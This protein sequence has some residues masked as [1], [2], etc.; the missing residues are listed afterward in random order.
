MKKWNELPSEMQVAEVKEYYDILEKR[1]AS[2]VLKR[3]FD[4]IASGIMIVILTPVMLILALFIKLD[5]KGPVMFRQR[6]VTTYNRVFRIYKFR[7]MVQNAESRGTQVTTNNDPRVTRV[8]KVIRGCRLD[9]LPQLF[10]VFLGDM[11]F[12]GTRPEVEKYVAAYTNEMKA[13]LLLPAGITSKAS[14]EYKDEE[15]L[16]ESAENTDEVYINEVL[17][18]KM[19]YNLEAIKN[20][21][22]FGDIKTMLETVLAVLK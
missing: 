6:R 2:L 13:T 11:T 1:N 4:I 9:E 14:I 16:L 20:F 7:S 21:S 5:S 22:F 8:G 18:E 12:V 19:K 3:I 10:N 15:R 17:P